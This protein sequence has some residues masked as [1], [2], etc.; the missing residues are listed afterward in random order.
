MDAAKRGERLLGVFPLADQASVRN[1]FGKAFRFIVSQRLLARKD[2]KGR[3]A[4][5]EILK[6][7]LRTRDYVEK[8]ESEGKTLLDAMRDGGTD[9]MQHFD[10]ELEKLLRAWIIDFDTAL[11]Y[12]PHAATFRVEGAAF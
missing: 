10:A 12:S 1:R 11:A 2:G 7:T 5:I 6:S 9:G 4:A 8:G 3:I